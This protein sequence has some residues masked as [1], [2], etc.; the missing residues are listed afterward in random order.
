MKIFH[1]TTIP[2]V[3]AVKLYTGLSE[4]IADATIIGWGVG[5]ANDST[6]PT[7]LDPDPYTTRWDDVGRTTV[8]KR[9]G[10]NTPESLVNISYG[11]G[12]YQA[13]VTTLGYFDENRP[14]NGANEAAVT[15]LDSGSGLFQFLSGEWQLIGLTTGV[16]NGSYPNST[17]ETDGTGNEIGT[18]NYFAR[19]SPFVT[20]INALVPEPSTLLLVSPA[21]LLLLR[22]RRCET[23]H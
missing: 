16:E 6:I 5:R 10:L 7:P 2:T 3:A 18:D 11:T 8:A 19:I 9:W 21:L 17:F 23:S 22:R 12:S 20:Q 14:D 13:I 1:L 15:L 4:Q